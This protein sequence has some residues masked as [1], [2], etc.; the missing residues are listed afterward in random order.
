MVTSRDIFYEYHFDK[1]PSLK[2][3]LRHSTLFGIYQG[4]LI[5]DIVSK[6]D[7]SEYYYNGSGAPLDT[8]LEFD[9]FS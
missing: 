3:E 7:S 9:R 1:T 2:G 6:K 8:I 4:D 5:S